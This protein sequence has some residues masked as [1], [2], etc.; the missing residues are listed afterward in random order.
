MA[1]DTSFLD[2]EFIVPADESIASFDAEEEQ[3]ELNFGVAGD[4]VIVVG[5]P[6]G[7][8][9]KDGRCGAGEG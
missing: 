5:A 7:E 2:L 4:E 6:G 1:D 8:S 3:V 9:K